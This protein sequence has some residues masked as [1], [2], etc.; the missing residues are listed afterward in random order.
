MVAEIMTPMNRRMN[1]RTAVAI[2]ER[3][4]SKAS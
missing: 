3:E 2:I 4:M 1:G